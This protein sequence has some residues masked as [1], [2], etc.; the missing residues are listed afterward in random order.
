[1]RSQDTRLVVDL[2]HGDRRTTYYSAAEESL[3][4]RHAAQ[5]RA[6][7]SVCAAG[8]ERPASLSG[9][10]PR[11]AC[12]PALAPGIAPRTSPTDAHARPGRTA[13]TW[14]TTLRA[15]SAQRRIASTA[16]STS[17]L[18]EWMPGAPAQCPLRRPLRRRALAWAIG[19]APP[20]PTRLSAPDAPDPSPPPPSLPAWRPLLASSQPADHQP[21]HPAAQHVHEPCAQRST[22]PRRPSR[23]RRPAQGPGVLRGE[24]RPERQAHRGC[25]PARFTPPAPLHPNSRAVHSL[26]AQDFYEDLFEELAKFGQ[27]EYLNVCDNL[28]DHMVGNCYVKFK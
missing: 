6:L 12:E 9:A 23:A 8:D 27:V 2:R 14:P 10:L 21:H 7:D 25:E 20:D 16:L 1:M 15:S 4:A 24:P 18:G 3:L 19:R 22:R 13:S 11:Q 17:R 5:E 26:R 28:A